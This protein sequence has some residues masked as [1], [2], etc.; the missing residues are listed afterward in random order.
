MRHFLP[1]NDPMVLIRNRGRKNGPVT[2]AVEV[3]SPTDSPLLSYVLPH[4]SRLDSISKA[5]PPVAWRCPQ[6]ES[7]VSRREVVAGASQSCPSTSTAQDNNCINYNK[8]S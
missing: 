5:P 2:A 6:L 4:T 1:I 8:H 7:T 3:T